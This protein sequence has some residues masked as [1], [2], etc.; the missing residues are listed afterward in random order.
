MF[1]VFNMGIGFCVVLSEG[2]SDEFMAIVKQ[3]GKEAYRIGHVVK[4]PAR[5]V[6]IGRY[7]LVGQGSAFEKV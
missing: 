1:R 3:H 7:G 4:D 6:L 5:K 2:D